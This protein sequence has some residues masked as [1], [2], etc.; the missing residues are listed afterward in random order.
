MEKV[1]LRN[2]EVLDAA[3]AVRELAQ[4]TLPAVAALKVVRVARALEAAAGDIL[5]VREQLLDRFTERDAEG[6]PVPATGAG[7]EELPGHVR[8]TD[9]RSFGREVAELL[10]GAT[11]LHAEPL[12]LAELGAD[13]ALAPRVLLMLGPVLVEDGA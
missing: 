9:P 7:G 4:V 13:F 5:K 8:L 10:A 2:S 3:Q 6:R 12:R 11:T 1:Q